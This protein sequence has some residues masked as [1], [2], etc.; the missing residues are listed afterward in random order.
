MEIGALLIAFFND[1][2]VEI[3]LIAIALDFVFGVLAAFKTGT[4]RLS[5]V[6]AFMKDDVLYKLL[7]YFIL[8]S[9]SKLIGGKDIVIPGLDL[10][11]VA[12]AVFATIIAAWV[13]SILSSLS[14]LGLFKRAP[15]PAPGVAAPARPSALETALF[16]P[17]NP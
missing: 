17:E 5:Y 16:G 8:Y 6:S 11:V 13:G 15:A 2:K 3:A 1:V 10:G 12:G 14:D 9:A 7:P 4:F